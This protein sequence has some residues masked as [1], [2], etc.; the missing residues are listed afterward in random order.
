MEQTLSFYQSK[1]RNWD[2][3]IDNSGDI[4]SAAFA[5]VSEVARV[6]S[7]AGF[8]LADRL[9]TVCDLPRVPAMME[10]T[11]KEQ[12]DIAIPVAA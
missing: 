9:S 2:G 1:D 6:S 10:R 5:C 11:R 7:E 8:A 3:A 12:A 4:G